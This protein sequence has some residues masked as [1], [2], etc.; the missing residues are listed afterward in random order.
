MESIFDEE[1]KVESLGQKVEELIRR[2]SEAREENARLRAELVSI[3]AQ[4]EAIS[5]QLGTLEEDAEYRKLSD[6]ELS[7]KLDEIFAKDEFDN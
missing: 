6:E 4:N 5:M 2:Y 1:K 3:K 7:K